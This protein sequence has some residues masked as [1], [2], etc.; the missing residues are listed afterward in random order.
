MGQ[1]IKVCSH[2]YEAVI[3][4]YKNMPTA[5]CKRCGNNFI[6]EEDNSETKAPSRTQPSTDGKAV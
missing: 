2:C 6:L 4:L 5:T 3:T 1:N